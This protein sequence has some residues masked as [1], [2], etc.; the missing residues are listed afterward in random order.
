MEGASSAFDRGFVVYSEEAKCDL[1]GL[2][3]ETIARCGVV[4][5]AVAQAMAEG[6]IAGSKADVAVAI[7]GFAGRAGEEDEVGLVHFATCTRDGETAQREEH[8]GDR[9]HGP[10]RLAAVDVAL[11]MLEE[12]LEKLA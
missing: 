1:L 2:A 7:T 11:T 10:I 4:S 8:F 5:G 3:P 12:A 9:G 6:A